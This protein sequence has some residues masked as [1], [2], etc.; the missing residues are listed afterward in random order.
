[1]QPLSAY[2]TDKLT[3]EANARIAAT[4]HGVPTAGVRFFNV[5]GPRQD[6]ASPYSGVISIFARKVRNGETLTVFGDGQQTRDFVYVSD[7]VAGLMATMR[8]ASLASP[9]YNICTGRGIS[10]LDMIAALGAQSGT[11]PWVEFAPPRA[12]D[13]RFSVGDPSKAKA[14]MGFAAMTGFDE[15]LERTYQSL[16]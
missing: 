1:M 12:G 10:L 7:A 3:A 6:P 16:T 9:V 11:Q 13:I 15:G 5:F 2:G 4:I 14:E 8:H